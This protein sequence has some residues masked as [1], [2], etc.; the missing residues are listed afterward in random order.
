M[1]EEQESIQG[2][3]CEVLIPLS[4]RKELFEVERSITKKYKKT[5]WSKFTKALNDFNLI[6]PGDKV[7]VAV[8]GGKDSLLLAKLFQELKRHRKFQFEVHF[9]TMDPGYHPHIKELHRENIDHLQIPIEIF[10]APVF[11]AIDEVARDY[12]CYLCARMRRGHLYHKAQ[13]LGCNK[14]ALGHHFNDVIE[15][16][17]LNIVFGGTFQAMPPKLRSDNFPEIEL[18]RPMYYIEEEVIKKWTK[19]MGIW[20]LNCACMVAAKRTGN[21]RYVIKDLIEK[22]KEVNPHADLNILRASQNVY[23]DTLLGYVS[24]GQ[25]HGFKEVYAQRPRN[26]AYEERAAH[27]ACPSH[28]QTEGPVDETMASGE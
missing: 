24:N 12:P 8:S 28:N 22:M 15:T 19:E 10:D 21:Q 18:I 1:L 5:I 6:E 27:K 17:M 23:Q 13:E 26:K 14:L 20:P 9:I 25:K 2:E 7:A 4:D 11:D 3:G 16:T